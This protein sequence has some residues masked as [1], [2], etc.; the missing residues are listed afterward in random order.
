M[1]PS[2]VCK[3]IKKITKKTYSDLLI[4]TRINEAC[5]LLS[6]TDKYV[7]EIC[8]LS[9]FKNLSGF[10]RS[11]KRIMHVTPKNYREIYNSQS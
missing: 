5:K 2:S 7:S 1:T 9:G 10:N 8:Y 11:F 4:E 6:D 3:F